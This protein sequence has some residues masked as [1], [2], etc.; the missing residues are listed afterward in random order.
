MLEEYFGAE[1]FN[2][3]DFDFDDNELLMKGLDDRYLAVA[4]GAAHYL[5]TK[6]NGNQVEISNVIPYC[7][8]YGKNGK[9]MRCISRNMPFGF[10]T[11]S[12][13]LPLPFLEK[14]SW[15]LPIYQCFSN[16][17]ELELDKEASAAVYMGKIK[18][19]E[20]LYEKK[21]SPLFKM[22]IMRDGRLRLQF[23]DNKTFQDGSKELVTTEE[24]FL[25]IG[26]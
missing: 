5:N 19:N 17:T 10:E 6:Q 3:K 16:Q 21:E 7:I 13:L 4:S 18:L 24:H 20:S 9:F 22:R 12:M 1:I 8:G 25:E 23:F 26:G 11:K 2:K 14:I 15:Q